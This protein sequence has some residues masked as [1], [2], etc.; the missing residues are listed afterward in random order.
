MFYLTHNVHASLLTKQHQNEEY[1]DAGN[2]LL[3]LSWRTGWV[4]SIGR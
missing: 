2:G 3:R 1:R 4:E